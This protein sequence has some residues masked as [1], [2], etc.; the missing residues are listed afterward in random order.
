M[1]ARNRRRLCAYCGK[2][3]KL[4]ADHV[5]PK[6]FL[7]QPFPANLMTVPA[8]GDCNQSFKAD[9]EYTRTILA[10][11]IRANWNNAHS[12]N[13]PRVLRSLQ[14][15]DARGFAEYL[16]S[17]SNATQILSAA[18]VPYFA[19]ELDNQRVKNTGLHI[20]RGLY[21]LETRKRLPEQ[22]KVHIG[23]TTDLTPDDPVMLTLARTVSCMPDHRNGSVGTAF[24]YFV[25]FSDRVSAW[26][27]LLYDYFFWVGTVD[28]REPS[29]SGSTV[30]VAP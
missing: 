24:S 6:L 29:G 7:E 27:M 12:S 14:G 20:L 1:S 15:P 11:D 9:D 4:T 13:F 30:P 2:A 5:P 26:L 8:C 25:A 19:I 17:Q 22:A 18:G 23:S 16:R 3:K 28:D 21:F 10:V